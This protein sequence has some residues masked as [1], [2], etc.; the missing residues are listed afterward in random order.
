VHQGHGD[1]PHTARR[2]IVDKFHGPHRTTSEEVHSSALEWDEIT[3]L[4]KESFPTDRATEPSD[5]LWTNSNPVQHPENHEIFATLHTGGYKLI[6]IVH[7]A[8]FLPDFNAYNNSS[9][10]WVPEK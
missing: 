10:D 8:V 6:L 9:G 4:L 1:S 2:A 7:K 3:D 5:A